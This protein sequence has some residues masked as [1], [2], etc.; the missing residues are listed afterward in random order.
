MAGSPKQK[1][2][3]AITMAMYFA[4]RG[5]LVSPREFSSDPIRPFGIKIST[6][7]KVFNY[8][9]IMFDYTKSFCADKLAVLAQEKPTALEALKAKT[10]NAEIEGANGKNI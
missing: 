6:I 5:F 2:K 9:P 1:K 10:V 4:E 7:R 8:W 3:L